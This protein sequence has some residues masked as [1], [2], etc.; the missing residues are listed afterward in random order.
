MIPICKEA[1]MQQSSPKPIK[2]GAL[3]PDSG[4]RFGAAPLD[5]RKATWMSI[6][7][8]FSYTALGIHEHRAGGGLRLGAG[9]RLKLVTLL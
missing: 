5:K 7:G 3:F 1:D 6:R 9:H 8:Y 2:A 4:T